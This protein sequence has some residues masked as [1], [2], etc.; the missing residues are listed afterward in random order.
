MGVTLPSLSVMPAQ[1]W[2]GAH[3][4]PMRF[5]AIDINHG[6]GDVEWWALEPNHTEKLYEDMRKNFKIDIY[7]N[8]AW[9]PD[10][11]FLLARGYSVNYGVQKPGDMALLSYG[12]M[13]WYRAESPSVHTSWNIAPKTVAALSKA[14]A[15]A[16][17]N[18]SIEYISTIHI[19]TLSMHLL[20]SEL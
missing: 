2:I 12:T 4:S 16:E 10:P 5:L 1:S 7:Q 11:N 6:P 8:E 20:N 15:R 17:L 19:S 14:L 9:W 3:E 13:H 18:R